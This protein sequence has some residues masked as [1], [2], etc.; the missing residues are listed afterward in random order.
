VK[1]A[2]LGALVMPLIV[3]VF[4]A[5]AVSVHAGRIGPE[6]AGPHGFTEILYALTSQGNNNGSAFGGLTGNTPF[7]NVIGLIDMLI[8]RVGIMIPALAIG[9][10]LAAKN[11]V[12]AG[13]GPF[14]TDNTMFV[15]LT[16]G[17]II[18]IGGLTF[19]PAVALGPILEQLLHGRFF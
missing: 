3:L 8:G 6:N 7:Y 9:G 13:L 4:M 14:R 16:I 15:G 2:G 19:F 11:I 5:I 17:V 1:L 12:P 18:I 10:S